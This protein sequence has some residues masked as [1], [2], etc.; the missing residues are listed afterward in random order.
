[1]CIIFSNYVVDFLT[2]G[3][4]FKSA[5]ENGKQDVGCSVL[6]T[7]CPFNQNSIV[8]GIKNLLMQNHAPSENK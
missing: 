7:K 2:D 1:M 5:I 4:K 3:S 6:Y 8:N